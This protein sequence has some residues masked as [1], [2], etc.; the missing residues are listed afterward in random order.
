[1]IVSSAVEGII[2]EALVARLIS[3]VG[4]EQGA[5]YGKAGKSRLLERL[6]GFNE[7]ARRFPWLVL[8]D[9]DADFECAPDALPVWLPAPS[10]WMCFRIAVREAEAWLLADR[11]SLAAYLGVSRAVVPRDPE[12]LADAKQALINVASHS[13]RRAIRDD[14]VP[15]AGSGRQ[16]GPGYAGR[17]ID[18]VQSRWQPDIAADAAPS[19]RRCLDAVAELVGRPEP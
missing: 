5:V 8:V 4:G 11:Q 16:V 6:R 15:R 14:I 10:P 19:L 7:A 12:A 3:H 18:F 9:L 1:M 17:V 2:D 13:R